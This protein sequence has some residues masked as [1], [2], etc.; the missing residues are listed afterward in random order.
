MAGYIARAVLKK[1]KYHICHIE[2]VC[3]EKGN[4]DH[5]LMRINTRAY[6]ADLLLRPNSYLLQL[7]FQ[8]KQIF[9]FIYQNIY[10]K[11]NT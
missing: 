5:D 9:I 6:R 10:C 4:E 8:L 7:Y 3:N 2:L 1:I 11:E